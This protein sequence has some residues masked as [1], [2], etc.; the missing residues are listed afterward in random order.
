MLSSSI[1]IIL[2]IFYASTLISKGCINSNP[3]GFVLIVLLNAIVW[4]MEDDN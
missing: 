2:T 3:Y 1:L 4:G